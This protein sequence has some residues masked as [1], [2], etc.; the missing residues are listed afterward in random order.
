MV[1]VLSPQGVVLSDLEFVLESPRG[2]L[3]NRLFSVFDTPGYVANA[4]ARLFP[5]VAP[6]RVFNLA[7]LYSISWGMLNHSGGQSMVYV[8]T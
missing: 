7:V 5:P 1:S 2:P 6:L 4:P 8:H 3:Y